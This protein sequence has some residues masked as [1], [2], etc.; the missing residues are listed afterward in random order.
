MNKIWI[1]VSAAVAAVLASL[2]IAA[3]AAQA[4]ELPTVSVPV[5]RAW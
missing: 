5:N 1:K 3:P 2:V 4:L